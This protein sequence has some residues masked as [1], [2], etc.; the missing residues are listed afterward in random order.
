MPLPP[1]IP[2]HLSRA[3]G[4]WQ[5][6]WRWAMPLAVVL[7]VAVV[8]GI[9][10]WTL[11]QWRTSAHASEPMQEALRRAR[12]NIDLVADFGEPMQ[13]GWLPVGSMQTN[14][15]GQRDVGLMVGLEGPHHHGQLFVQARRTDGVWDYPVVYVLGQ[16]HQTYDLS[17]LDDAEA[18]QECALRACRERGECV[19]L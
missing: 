9:T 10:G 15:N 5:R 1:P 16:N 2:P 14:F 4:W 3:P 11:W 17:A 13:P 19:A 7:T 8:V 18:A 6:H 12:C